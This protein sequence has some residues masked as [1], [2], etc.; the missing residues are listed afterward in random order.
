MREA[1]LSPAAITDN[2]GTR[3]MG[4]RVYYYPRLTS[5]MTAAREMARQGATEG[6][7]VIADEQTAGRGRGK[8]L[9]L[10]PQGNI[11]LSIILYPDKAYLP[12]LVMISSLA[13]V[14]SIKEV[15]GL[16]AQIKWPNDVL[17]SSKK[18][19]GILIESQVKGGV[20]VYAIVGIG[21]NVN[22]RVTDYPEIMTSATS[23]F[24]ELGREVSRVG[25]IRCLLAELERLYL[26]LPWGDSVYRE[27]REKLVTL[28]RRV[29]VI[30]GGTVHEGI[31]ESVAP[32]GS[33]MLRR[34]DGSIRTIIAGDVTL[35]GSGE[36]R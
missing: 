28:G 17:I 12:S 9:W 23:L 16:D 34:D 8:R 13:V 22:L 24:Q 32:D 31:A 21:V 2:L 36:D 29:R 5:T 14:H 10:T 6:T 7:V 4:G 15:T 35:G 18:V 27:W 20:V 25:L 26:S 30:S 19:C 1:N 11:A 3:F 33:L